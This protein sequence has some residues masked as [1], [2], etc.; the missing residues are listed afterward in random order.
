VSPE[1][2]LLEGAA[3]LIYLAKHPPYRLVTVEMGEDSLLMP[4]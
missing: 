4:G 2:L 3:P 1:K